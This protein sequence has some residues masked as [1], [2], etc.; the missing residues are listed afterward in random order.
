M[1]R[2]ILNQA[3]THAASK[4]RHGDDILVHMSKDEIKEFNKIRPVTRNPDTGFPEMFNFN[5]IVPYIAPVVA[6]LGGSYI[7]P[8]IFDGASTLGTGLSDLVFDDGTVNAILGGAID[9]GIGAGAAALAGGNPWIGAGIGGVGSAV[10]QAGYLDSLFGRGTSAGSNWG[11]VNE[12]GLLPSPPPS[13][14]YGGDVD[15]VSGEVNRVN[16]PDNGGSGGG[17]L[18]SGSGRGR[19][20]SGRGGERSSTET[21]ARLGVAALPIVAGLASGSSK[22]ATTSTPVVNQPPTPAG[23]SQPIQQVRLVRS[24][25][26]PEVDW[27]RAGM[28]PGGLRFYDNPNG[29]FVAAKG[30]RA[31]INE[32]ARPTTVEGRARRSSMNA[33]PTSGVNRRVPVNGPSRG[34]DPM[35]RGGDGGQ[36]DTVPALLSHGEYVWDATTVADIGDGNSEA[37]AKK[38]DQLRDRIAGHKGRRQ[39]VPR[40]TGSLVSHAR[41][42]GMNI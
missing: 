38:L 8:M 21:L 17:G 15:S 36:D 9:A 29:T 16:I 39:R 37:G 7:A 31:A 3:L 19:S 23:F 2:S 30:G 28:Q 6:S 33:V 12:D 40:K 34:G 20:G 5:D 27:I 22:P 42:I 13:P 35:L 4:G 1:K 24:Y 10:S 25:R 11:V 32:M 18:F 14:P 26:A 41:S